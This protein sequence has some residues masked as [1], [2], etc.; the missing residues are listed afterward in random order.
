MNILLKDNIHTEKKNAKVISVQ[1][2]EFSQSGHTRVF[3]TQM[4]KQNILEP[5]KSPRVLPVTTPPLAPKVV[6]ILK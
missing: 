4:Q 1:L 2:G 6:A 3:S 5:H